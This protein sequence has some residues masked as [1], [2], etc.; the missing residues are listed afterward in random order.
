MNSTLYASLTHRIDELRR[1]MLPATFSDIGD[2]TE[3]ERDIA[4]GFRVL[5]HAEIEHYLEELATSTLDDCAKVFSTSNRV[6]RV[7]L[8]FVASYQ[9]GWATEVGEESPFTANSR[10]KPKEHFSE[11]L[12]R[13]I[14]QYKESIIK[15]NNGVKAANLKTIFVPLGIDFRESS[16]EVDQT[17]LNSINTFG[18][19]RGLTA[20]KSKRVHNQIDPKSEFDEVDAIV[21]GLKE[22][23]ALVFSLSQ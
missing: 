22:F 10:A 19:N 3:G 4:L 20:H 16:D 2:Y 23:D 9:A 11:A 6:S 18:T 12:N 8:A 13:A 5:A 1:H 7:I 21:Q 15:G 14:G 17:W